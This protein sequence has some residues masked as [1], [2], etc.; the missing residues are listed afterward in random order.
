MLTLDWYQSVNLQEAFM[1]F[2]GFV[3]QTYTMD[4]ISFDNQ[5]SIN[6]FP[7]VSESGSSKSATAL[8][9]CAGYR[10]FGELG[11]GAIRGA[12]TCANGRA[13]V[14]SGYEA[15]EVLSNGT[16]SL[17]GTITTGVGTVGI[18]E[19][20]TELIIV[21]GVE[22]YIYNMDTSTWSLISDTDFPV[23]DVVAFQD[24]YFIV[25]DHGTANFYIS[26]LYDGLSWDALDTSRTDSNPDRLVSIL[27]D[28]GN[29]W[30]FGEVSV[31][32]FYN[33]GAL[34][35]PFERISGAVINTGC[36]AAF[37]VQ[38]FDNTIAWLGVDEQGRGVVWK[39]NGYSAQ[40]ISTQAIENIIAQ[41]SDFT[42]SYAYVYH[43]RGHVFYCLQVKG[44][45]TTLVYD[46]AVGA[47][48]ERQWR[49]NVNSL[50]T[51]H[52]GACHFFFNQQNLIGDRENGKIYLQSMDIYDF[53]GDNIIRT[54]VSPHI[55]EEKKNIT[56]SS[57]ELDMETG[58]GT[59]DGL[60]P[61][62]MMSYSD[63]GGHTFSSE[64]WASAGQIGKYRTR[65]R[66][67]RLGSARDRVFKIVYSEKTFC[68]INEALINNA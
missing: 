38:K 68:Q 43:E 9:S 61:Q 64:K 49:D 11:G 5:R 15:Y 47:W 28:Q 34:A 59:I 41:S 54:R 63:D 8:A 30:L 66:W 37:T 46:S 39:A 52:R 62:V 21:D 20:G 25:N 18:E 24:G 16:G 19:N 6:F 36:A 60:N 17:I 35:F 45:D 32:V 42:G 22:G 33:S 48:H 51:Q 67:S 44:L 27:S 31:E 55:Q 1:K 12:K 2:N 3:G 10:L 58:V 65:V 56:Y 23:A 29:L 14:V 53:D 57:F 50:N 26:G 13:F 4:A 7:L 40:R